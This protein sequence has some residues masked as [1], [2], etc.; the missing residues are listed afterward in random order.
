MT[1]VSNYVRVISNSQTLTGLGPFF[2]RR[3]WVPSIASSFLA[4]EVLVD[5]NI[6]SARNMGCFV[7]LEARFG[8]REIKATVA[9]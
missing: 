2:W 5:I 8:I 3:E 7:H 9:Y 6:D 4:G 1:I